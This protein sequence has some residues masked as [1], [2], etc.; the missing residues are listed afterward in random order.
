MEFRSVVSPHAEASTFEMMEVWARGYSISI[1]DQN[2]VIE[3][4]GVRA[5]L[6]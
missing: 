5:A 2:D 1:G 3:G 4:F 6:V